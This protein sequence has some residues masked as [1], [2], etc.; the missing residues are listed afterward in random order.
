[1]SEMYELGKQIRA[2]REAY[3]ETQLELAAALGCDSPTTI[4]MY[5]N[6]WRGRDKYDVV[7]KIA[8]HYRI[9]EEAL[10]HRDY[11]TVSYMDLMIDD[12]VILGQTILRI[13]PIQYS[14]LA[15]KDPTFLKTW[16]Q[17]KQAA[18]TMIRSMQFQ[19]QAFQE[20]MEGYRNILES[21]KIPEAAANMLWWLLAASLFHRYPKI[22]EGLRE[23]GKGKITKREFFREY[24]LVSDAATVGSEY[25]QDDNADKEKDL[26]YIGEAEELL[27]LLY[28][29]PEGYRIVDYYAACILRFGIARN[30][31]SIAVAYSE[32]GEEMLRMLTR[33]G[34]PY[35][36]EYLA[37]VRELHR[38]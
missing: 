2:L 15:G 31:L 10:L 35:A 14:K 23:L 22:P 32:T 37:A 17:H 24:Y 30:T 7:S 27:R 6:G 3:G 11:Q 33:I 4:S 38:V 13:L 21:K 26:K 16:K 18:D 8:A 5:E 1:M 12:P 20:C 29:M 28:E 34:N 25:V 36:A 9:T 19:E